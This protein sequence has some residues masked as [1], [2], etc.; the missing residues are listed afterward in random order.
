MGR[1]RQELKNLHRA[2]KK[3]ESKTRGQ[4]HKQ[5]D[6]TEEDQNKETDQVK[7]KNIKIGAKV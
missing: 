7:H 3:T 5:K 2:L 1:Q 6:K 4:K